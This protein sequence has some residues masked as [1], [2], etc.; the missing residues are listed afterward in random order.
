MASVTE[1]R[2]GIANNLQA[3]YGL[4]VSSTFL[5]APRPPVAMVLPDR[6]EYDLNANR[7]AD[8]YIFTVS[9]LVGRADDRAAQNTMDQFL[10]GPDS[11]KQAIEA[12]R[13]LGG[14]ANTCRVTE[15]R[16]YGQVTVG[17]VVYL[18]VEFE[19][20]VVA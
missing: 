19:V 18:G 4:R 7:G 11:A 20:E 3:V 12:D 8:T 13:T 5:D 17:D 9:L 1:L 16:N 2:Q 10:V 14:A 15:M 6:I